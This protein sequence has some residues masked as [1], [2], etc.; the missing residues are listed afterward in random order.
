VS[1][2]G[3]LKRCLGV[4]LWV[5]ALSLAPSA[6][7]DETIEQLIARADAAQ[8]GRQPDLYLEVAERELKATTE[9]YKASKIEEGRA[10]L[11]N[12]VTYADK[13]HTSAIRS[14]KRLPHTEIKIRRISTR[15]RDLKLDVDVDDQP[16][17]QAAID[18]LEGFRTDI[19][20]SLFPSEKHE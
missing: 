12:I 9:S 11:E 3:R 8:V 4:L 7:K 10:G 6:A 17:V 5:I 1:A 18:K 15:L 13:A 19:L 16:L 20:K 2:K 14:G